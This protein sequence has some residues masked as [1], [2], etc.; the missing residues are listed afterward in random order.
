[1]H[2]LGNKNIICIN[3]NTKLKDQTVES[4]V[5]YEKILVYIFLHF[6]HCLPV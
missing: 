3:D 4:N 1:M 5:K 6:F 2:N